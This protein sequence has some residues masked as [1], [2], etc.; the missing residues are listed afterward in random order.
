MIKVK[1]YIKNVGKST[2]YAAS[3]VLGE[4]YSTLRDFKNTN[5]EVFKES[6][7]AIKDYRTTFSRVKTQIQKTDVYTA[8]SLGVNNLISD[9]KSGTFYNKE[10]EAEYITKYGGDLMSNSD[11]D[12]DES[13]FNW[14]DKTDV[15]DGEKIIA[16]AIKKN[17]K[18]STVIMADAMAQGH[19]GII[20]SSRENTT[21]LY[22]QQEKMF[23]KIGGGLDNITSLLRGNME[24]T[25]RVQNRQME[26]TNKFYTNMEKKTDTIVAQLDEM[27]KMQR[28]LYQNEMDKEKERKRNTVTDISSGGVPDLKEYSKLVKGNIKDAIGQMTGGASSMG[29]ALGGANIFAMFASNPLG[30]L[31]KMGVNKAIGTDFKKASKDFDKSLKGLFSTLMSKANSAKNS[32]DPIAKALGTIFGIKVDKESDTLRTDKYTRGPIPFDGVTKKAITEVMP[33]YLRKMTSIL[34]GEDEQV[35]D[36][37]TGKWTTVKAVQ[38]RHNDWKNA[39]ATQAISELTQLIAE[40]LGKDTDHLMNNFRDQ[41]RFKENYQKF[42]DSLYRSNGDLNV[43][44]KG[45]ESGIDQEFLDTIKEILQDN[46]YYYTDKTRKGAKG[47]TYS[48]TVIDRSKGTN[49]VK[50]GLNSRSVLSNLARNIFETKA[51]RADQMRNMETESDLIERILYS[52]GII[53]D[54]DSKNNPSIRNKHGD[55]N[56]KNAFKSPLAQAMIYMKDDNGYT[57]FNYLQYIKRD[58]TAIRATGLNLSA[59]KG[60]NKKIDNSVIKSNIME[61]EKKDSQKLFDIDRGGSNYKDYEKEERRNEDKYNNKYQRDL[62]KYNSGSSKKKP[63]EVN[64]FKDIIHY[65]TEQQIKLEGDNKKKLKNKKDLFDLA[66][67]FNIIS[68]EDANKF[69]EIEYSEDKSMKENMSERKGFE[70]IVLLRNYAN[71]LIQKPW[72]AVTDAVINVD[73]WMSDFL[74]GKAL[75]KNKEDK[76]AEDKGLLITFK[77]KI[78]NTFEDI[79]DKVGDKIGKFFEDKV[80]PF[81]K[82]YLDPINKFLFGE[83]ADSESERHGGLFGDFIGKVGSAFKRNSLEVKEYIK[84]T[85]KDTK[86]QVLG[87]DDKL[88]NITNSNSV[89]QLARGGIN[90]SGK[91]FHS[92]VSSGEI[93][94]G[95]IVPPGGPYLTTIPKGGYVINPASSSTI[96]KQAAQER[97]FI[98]KLRSN[99]KADDGLSKATVVEYMK[100]E[101]NQKFA[102]DVVAKGGIGLGAGLLLGHPLL[103]AG[104]GIVSG[105]A[106]KS[107]KFANSIFGSAAGTD[108]DGNIIRNDDGLISKKI[109]EAIPD[110]KKFGLGG[111]IAGLITP[112]GPLGGLMIGSAIGFAKNNSMIQ[113]TLFGDNGLIGKD[114]KDKLKKA[115][116]AMGIGAASAALLGPFG[117]VGNAVLGA[118]AGY[119]TSMDK[120]KNAIFGEEKDVDTGKKD[121]DGNPIMDKKRQG[122]LLGAIKNG[123]EPLKNFGRTI[124]DGITDAIFG[125]KRGKDGKREGGLFGMAKNQIIVP[126]ADGLKPIIQEAKNMFKKTVNS[127]TEMVKKHM[128]NNVGSHTMDKLGNLGGKLGKAG[129]KIGKGALWLK[130]APLMLGAKAV[131]GVGAGLRRKQIRRGEADDM[132]ASERLAYR[133]QSLFMSGGDEFSDYDENLMNWAHDNSVENMEEIQN[134]LL[135]SAEGENAISAKDAMLRKNFDKEISEYL[136]GTD[137]GKVMSYIKGDSTNYKKAEKLIRAGDLKDHRGNVIKDHEREKLLASLNTLKKDRGSIK[138]KFENLEEVK[139]K[140]NKK[141]KDLGIDLNTLDNKTAKKYAAYLNTEIVHKKAGLTPEEDPHSPLNQNTTELSKVKEALTDL[142]KC[143]T[144]QKEAVAEKYAEEEK[145]KEDEANEEDTTENKT[146]SKVDNTLKTKL[147]TTKQFTPRQRMLM[148]SLVSE[149]SNMWNN[150]LTK[151]MESGPNDNGEYVFVVNNTEY[152]YSNNKEYDKEYDRCIDDYIRDKAPGLLKLKDLKKESV[153]KNSKMVLKLKKLGLAKL[154]LILAMGW[155]GVGAAA[156]GYGAFKAVKWGVPKLTKSAIGGAKWLGKGAVNLVAGKKTVVGQDEDGNDIVRR[157][158]GM[159]GGVRNAISGAVENVTKKGKDAKLGDKILAKL[160]DL[161]HK[162]GKTLVG[163]KNKSGLLSK[164]F[165]VTK[166]AVGVP[167]M[168]GFLKETVFPFLKNKVGPLFLGTKNQDGEYEGGLI[169]GI[170][171]PLRKAFKAPFQKVRDW[172]K[173]EGEFSGGNSGMPG[174]IKNFKSIADYFIGLWKSGAETIF[175]KWIPNAVGSLVRNL[176][177]VIGN[178]LMNI[179]P[180]LKNIWKSKDETKV[181]SSGNNLTDVI[182]TVKNGEGSSSVSK[183]IPFYTT[184][185]QVFNITPEGKVTKTS[186]DSAMDSIDKVGNL[187]NSSI[188]SSIQSVKGLNND[189]V[190][191]GGTTSSGDKIYYAKDDKN[192]TT[193]LRIDP[194]TGEFYKASDL[195]QVADNSLISNKVYQS[196]INNDVDGEAVNLNNTLGQRFVKNF[197]AGLFSPMYQTGRKIGGKMWAGTGKVMKHIPFMGTAGRLVE[198]T[199]NLM[200]NANISKQG[201]NLLKDKVTAVKNAPEKALERMKSKVTKVAESGTKLASEVSEKSLKTTVVKDKAKDA[202]KKAVD[203]VG[204]TKS[205][206]VIKKIVGLLKKILNKILTCGPVKKLLAKMGKEGISEAAEK[207]LKE[208]VEKVAK[209]AGETLAKKGIRNIISLPVKL[210]AKVSPAGIA[211]VVA[212]FVTGMADARNILK[213]TSEEIDVSD[214]IIAGFSKVLSGLLFILPESTC[215][216]LILNTIGKALFK[217]KVEEIQKEQKNSEEALKAYNEE[218]GKDLSIEEYNNEHNANWYT[219]TKNIVNKVTKKAWGGIK[220]VGKGLWDNNPIGFAANAIKGIKDKGLIKGIGSA[221]G[222]TIVGKAGKAVAKG[223]K[224]LW[225][226]IRGNAEAD[227]GLEPLDEDTIETMTNNSTSGLGVDN[228][229][230]L[231]TIIGLLKNILDRLPNISG[232]GKMIGGAFS[233]KKGLMGKVVGKM[234]K[235]NANANDGLTLLDPSSLGMDSVINESLDTATS[236]FEKIQTFLSRFNSQNKASNDMINNGKVDPADKNFWKIKFTKTGNPMIDSMFKM[237]EY[238]SRLIKAPFSMVSKTMGNVNNIIGTNDYTGTTKSTNTSSTTQDQDTSEKKESIWTKIKNKFKSIFGKGDDN[239]GTGGVTDP[240]HIYQRD[241]N[242]S[243]QTSGDS[244]RQTLADSGCGPAA[245]VTVANRYGL[246]DNLNNAARYATSNGYKEVNGGTYPSYFSDYL[247]KK[248]IKTNITQSNEDVVKS[249]VRGKPVIMMGQDKSNSG[250]SPYG[251]KY[252]H[253]VVATGIDKSG[254]VIVEDSEDR[255]SQTKYNLLDTLKNTSVKITTSGNGRYGRGQSGISVLSEY[256]NALVKG[257][258]GPYYSALFGDNDGVTTNNSSNGNSGSNPAGISS[259]EDSADVETRKKIIWNFLTSKG[260]SK[261]LAAAIMGNM[262]RESGFDPTAGE[263]ASGDGGA[264]SILNMTH[265]QFGDPYGCGWGLCQWSYAPGHAALYNW[266]TAHNLSADTLEGQLNYLMAGLTGN[267]VED[268]VNSSN[269]SKFGGVDG[270]GVLSYTYSCVV[271]YG[272]LSALNKLS[273]DEAVAAFYDLYERGANR[274]SD[275]AKSIP[276]AKEIYDQF[277][278]GSGSGKGKESIG[279]RSYRRGNSGKGRTYSAKSLYSNK[280]GRSNIK[281]YYGRADEEVLEETPSTEPVDNGET[282]PVEDTSNQPKSALEAIG[283]YTGRLMKSIYG[284]YWKAL[285]GPDEDTDLN[286]Q[287]AAERERQAANLNPDGKIMAP[288][289][290]YFYVSQK[291]KGTDHDG[292][293]IIAIDN[294]TAGSSSKFYVYSTIDGVVSHSGWQ[295]PN[296]HGAGFGQYVSITDKDDKVWYFGHLESIENGITEGKNITKGTVLGVMGTT[297][298]ST[299]KHVHYCCRIGGDKS[300]PIDISQAIGIP[301]EDYED[302]GGDTLKVTYLSQLFTSFKNVDGD[303]INTTTGNISNGSGSGKGKG[304]NPSTHNSQIRKTNRAKAAN[305]ELNRRFNSSMR[306]KLVDRSKEDYLYEAQIG[307][308]GKKSDGSGFGYFDNVR[309]SQNNNSPSSQYYNNITPSSNNL[310]TDQLVSILEIIADNSNKT[311][312]IVQLLA[313]IVTNTSISNSSSNNTTKINQLINQIK[314]NTSSAPL[315]GLNQVLNNNGNNIANAVYSIAKS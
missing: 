68:K 178:V 39:G 309:S 78:V 52:E 298:T 55:F 167:L 168:V 98:N 261:N 28:N 186:G 76:D 142:V 3:D 184:F 265:P 288:F 207:A 248:G 182:Q 154:S 229:A 42:I 238:M 139:K 192:K 289:D 135:M 51:S 291:Y 164:I 4:H 1:E 219:K 143:L 19:K 273:I 70:K 224:W 46:Q 189:S 113:D 235:R 106:N 43:L 71:K 208:S 27:I 12:M 303:S 257:I 300:N 255:R 271:N 83:K 246:K 176:P 90:K 156:L 220:K 253:Y 241:Y 169:S 93:V 59:K 140:T 181:G 296:N 212:D 232:I 244:E 137:A 13:D 97:G 96:N 194:E 203:K 108:K 158:G 196:M 314:N 230:P 260:C 160:D 305:D 116:P 236:G 127:L 31:M 313:A 173:G 57:L 45:M 40:S 221:V 304:I 165:G 100:D 6:Y 60:R 47:R 44:N 295:D 233:N 117:L 114:K 11:W 131:K 187:T 283:T 243:Y 25:A 254:N 277:A 249:L 22:V 213:I 50:T 126:I 206:G 222:K 132:T 48:K 67:E 54:P 239:T 272:G 226:K 180:M 148:D 171:N 7:S 91:A 36:Y 240:N 278:N 105:F 172:F 191:E 179:W 308:R 195:S 205:G 144:G 258:Y 307:G 266:C 276:W 161:P 72:E 198:G 112:F 110:V 282:A 16:T 58:L 199:G 136:K 306:K 49:G 99:A 118:T 188:N 311:D 301:N 123:M 73:K 26:N 85:A 190:V 33:F 174:M 81:F 65:L 147:K 315:S 86:K 268:A 267:D 275:L 104:I 61:F 150:A 281:S 225:G 101:E 216:S 21:L 287:E 63:I 185:G 23:N 80:Q 162:I 231:I 18:M 10:R 259:I 183:G 75:A 149:A 227:D 62:E 211:F 14:D 151:A 107:N 5:Q 292:M 35:F 119:V 24:N 88:Q 125:K 121:K 138:G 141:L 122:G 218:Y 269:S 209:E 170:V 223:A 155:T 95:N 15:S 120:F 79:S 302:Y 159:F 133:K 201:L 297:G 177:R 145:K 234:L 9:L 56:T 82:K 175:S 280:Y 103:A 284:D 157:K 312:Q 115:L 200:A 53:M 37:K 66:V 32:N 294:A 214:K 128:E 264:K 38:K 262:K 89:Q 251:S 299:G 129:I 285:F 310:N 77:D 193:P 20:D 41:K 130:A 290:G 111:A 8:A 252:S 274:S 286:D 210:A 2:V 279:N 94:N 250:K 293:D 166:V 217:D 17:N 64:E 215:C 256:S 228:T 29:D 152:R 134:I 197:A 263:I 84:K 30:A 202:A 146:E 74:F 163:D 92:V 204:D 124:V 153:G 270:N 242:G 109:Q 245:A 237:Q 247:S 34:T 102:A 69:K 87:E